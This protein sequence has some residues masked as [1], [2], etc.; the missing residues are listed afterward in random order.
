MIIIGAKG[1]AKEV[2]E[3]LH[4]HDMTGN[5]AFYDDVS[6]DAPAMLFGRFPVY[7]NLEQVADHFKT[8]RRFTIG[9]GNPALRKTLSERFTAVGGELTSAVSDQAAIGS[10][11][12]TIGHG[13]NVLAG[14]SISNDVNI[15][16][17][18]LMYYNVVVTHDC[19]VGDFVELSPSVTLLGRCQVGSFTHIGAGSIVLPDV[20]IGSNVIIGAGSLVTKDI[21][22]NVLAYGHPAK[23][24]HNIEPKT[25]A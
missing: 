2:L 5:L 22:D 17:G 9:V 25:D 21:P 12:V 16:A 1:F 18:C 23:V 8:D 15:G 6:P 4:R 19:T 14:V 10:Y 20:K 13:S 11:G 7:R 24:I 3:V